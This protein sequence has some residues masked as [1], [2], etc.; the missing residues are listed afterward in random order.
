MDKFFSRNKE[1]KNAEFSIGLF[2]GSRFP[3]TLHNFVLI[4][5]IIEALSDL[6]YFQK[7]EFNFAIVNALSSS[8]IKEIF[9]KRGWLKIEK[10]KD[11]NLLKF[12]TNF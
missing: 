7:I 10:I 6:R 4:L 3:E 8:K 9:Q 11:N 12:N 1:F 5:E 2:P